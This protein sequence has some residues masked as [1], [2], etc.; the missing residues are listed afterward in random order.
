MS[1]VPRKAGA[2]WFTISVGVVEASEGDDMRRIL[3]RGRSALH[4]A[5][6]QGRNC[7]V[8]RDLLGAQFKDTSALSH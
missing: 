4:A 5:I 3:Q 6:N 8:G 1:R 7:V 2:G